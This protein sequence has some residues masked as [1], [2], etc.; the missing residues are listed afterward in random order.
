[1]HDHDVRV[2][3]GQGVG[4]RRGLVGAGVV[5]DDELV[6]ENLA[7]LAQQ[8]ALF[9]TES[10]GALDVGLLVP[11]RKEDAELAKRHDRRRLRGRALVG[12]G[13]QR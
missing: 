3:G 8:L 10:N 6:V 13:K 1:M 12:H 2:R 5:D 7:P 9:L 11:H 4:H